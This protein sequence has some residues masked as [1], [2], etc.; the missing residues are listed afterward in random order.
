M[1]VDHDTPIDI[2]YMLAQ[3]GPD[4]SIKNKEGK[5]PTDLIKI[6]DTAKM[7]VK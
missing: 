6:K 2:P 7:L 1:E 4:F 3:A 5:T